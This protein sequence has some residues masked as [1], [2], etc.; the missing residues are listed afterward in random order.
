VW[1]VFGAKGF[2][3]ETLEAADGAFMPQLTRAL[4]EAEGRSGIQMGQAVTVR[5]FRSTGAFR[6][7]TLAPGWVAAFTEGDWIA[8][9][10]LATLASRRLLVA[11]ARHEFLHALV[12]G[13]AAPST[14]LWLREGLV[15]AWGDDAPMNGTKPAMKLDEIDGALSQAA[16]EA[17]SQAAHRAAGW[18][19]QRLLDRYGRGQVLQWL[20]TGLPA[21]A[22]GGLK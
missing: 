9:Q 2:V 10:P 19:A 17:Q 5:A 18:Y 1:Q 7:A 21:S 15:E 11:T 12:E 16:T 14:Q 4:G 20:E 8:M 13:K 22:V 6:D 3:L